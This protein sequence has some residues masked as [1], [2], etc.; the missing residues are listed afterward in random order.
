MQIIN[1]AM[2]QWSENTCI[3][4]KERERERNY[5]LVHIGQGYII[6]HVY[7]ILKNLVFL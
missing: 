1:A 5:A 3:K 7:F 6:D 2:K 4:F